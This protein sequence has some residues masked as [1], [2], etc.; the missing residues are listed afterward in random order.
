MSLTQGRN[1]SEPIAVS[2]QVCIIGSGAG[3]SVLAAELAARGIGVVVVEEGPYVVR[4]DFSQK[5]GEAYPA[6]YQDRFARATADASIAILQ[7]R[8]VG[9]GTTVNWTT[10]FRTPDAV[11]AVWKDRFGLDLDLEPHFQAVEE[12]LNI[13]E[14]PIENANNA[15]LKTGCEALGWEW[16][17]LRRNVLGCANSGYCGLGC[18]FDAKQAMLITTIQDLLEAGGRLFSD[19]RVE[20]IE[21]DGRRATRVHAVANGHPVT[22]TADKVV[23]A[24]GAINSPALLLK[25]DVNPNGLV[26]Q[27]TYLHPVVAMTGIYPQVI[28]GWQG[29][30]Q[31]IGSHQFI[32][33]YG[34][35]S[36]GPGWFMECPP[37]QP[38]LAS[39]G[40]MGFGAQQHEFM[41]QLPHIASFLSIFADGFHPEAPG[42]TVTLRGDG[43]P[44]V[45]YPISEGLARAMGEAHVAMARIH[46][47]AGA[48]V[49]ASLHPEPIQVRSEADLAALETAPYGTLKHSIFTAHQMGGCRMHSDAAQ[50]V[51]TPDHKVV[52]FDNLYVVDGS[53]LPTSLGVNPSQT[54]YS[55]AHRAVGE[56]A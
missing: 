13:S 4:K 39:A 41:A 28:A 49:C 17:R 11:Q 46:L 25:S 18:P 8:S 52:G 12:R 2:T 9:G 32:G 6:L 10:C 7:G 54:I 19:T 55:L 37:L 43:R 38:M 16:G 34:Q 1:V 48:E 21:N 50:A 56:L 31:S 45:D 42:G 3:G 53:V 5:E 29:A 22:I 51:V 47:A 36:G 23:V 30:P 15:T 26:G 44:N 35:G 20:H 24:G 14:W 40:F 27:H 33:S